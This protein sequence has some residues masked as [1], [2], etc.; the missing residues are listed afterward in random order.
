MN[1]V[2]KHIYEILWLFFISLS[3]LIFGIAQSHAQTFSLVKIIDL[4]PLVGD[5]GSIE[6]DVVGDELYVAN[7]RQNKYY[8]IDPVS[9]TVLGLFTLGGGILIDNHGSEYNP[10]KE[11]ILHAR[12]DDA[13]GY[14]A[15]D[16]FFETDISGTLIDGP[17]DL[18]GSGDNSE[19]PESLTIDPNTS[20]IWVSAVS[21]PGGITEIDPY[22][23]TVINQINIGGEAWA[24]GYN[25]NSGNLFFA[26]KYGVIWEIAPDGTG[27]AAVFDP[28]V[29]EIYGMAFAPSGDLALLEFAAEGYGIPP[30]SRLLLYDSSDDADSEFTTSV[31]APIPEDSD[32][33][34]IPDDEDACLISDLSDT[35]VI[36]GIDSGVEN[37]L[38]DDGCT[39]SDLISQCAV[40]VVN[41]GEFVSLVSHT[42]N[43]LKK[44]RI[45]SGKDKGMIQKCAAKAD[46][47]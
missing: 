21:Y 13:G 28:G 16:A 2:Y 40:E 5:D 32:G 34:G 8:R 36:D 45:I 42:V 31:P 37:V 9:S 18:F 14:P 30:P 6:V 33:D 17:Y 44:S 47:K 4:S 20:R 43:F 22:D 25:P 26:D 38:L 15:F 10:V 46:I 24:L 19:D 27:L 35:V 1:N 3:I 12:D 23:S 29:G 39:I 11:T 41:H 7:W